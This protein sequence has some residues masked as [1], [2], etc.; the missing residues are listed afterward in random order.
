MPN[1]NQKSGLG[2]GAAEI[3]FLIHVTCIMKQG[4][5]SRIL[6]ESRRCQKPILQVVSVYTRL[7][8]PDDE[9][10]D[11]ILRI[12]SVGRVDKVSG[13]NARRCIAMGMDCLDDLLCA[14]DIE[15]PIASY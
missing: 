5:E 14:G 3:R 9:H 13:Q 10:G 1:V 7:S 11:I 4:E 12:A 2:F 8:D 6:R 15:I